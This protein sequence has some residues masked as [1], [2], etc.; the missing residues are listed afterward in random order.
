MLRQI[1]ATILALSAISVGQVPQQKRPFTFE[2]M[3]ALKRVN[4]P[5]VS[6]DGKWVAFSAHEINLQANTKTSHLWVVLLAGGEARQLTSGEKGEDRPGWSPDGR[7]LGYISPKEAGS[8]VWTVGFNSET[9]TLEGDAKR[10]TNISTEADGEL[11]SPDGKNIILVSHKPGSRHRAQLPDY[12]APLALVLGLARVKTIALT[13]DFSSS[14][15]RAL[16]QA[17]S[18]YS[19]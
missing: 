8:Q 1:I 11:W 18:G 3:M 16:L 12:R 14:S 7:R 17:S 6:P 15:L 13:L 19:G 10:I 5:V 2:D 4:E 9:G